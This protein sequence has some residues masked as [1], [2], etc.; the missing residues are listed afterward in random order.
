MSVVWQTW[1]GVAEAARLPRLDARSPCRRCV[2]RSQVRRSRKCN[3]WWWE[4][5]EMVCTRKE[6]Y[7]ELALYSPA[8]VVV[9]AL[10]Q[11]LLALVLRSER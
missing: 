10:L 3:K 9:E 11:D 2:V 7:D 8:D 5:C 4:C 1:Y 6:E